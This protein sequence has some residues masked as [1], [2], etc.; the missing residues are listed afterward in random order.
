MNCRSVCF[1]LLLVVVLLPFRSPAPLIYRPGEGWTYESVG[2]ESGKWMRPRAKEQLE[3][4]QEAFDKKDY[5]LSLKAAHRVMHV[6][7]LSDF[8]PQAQYLV[9]RSYEAKGQDEKAFK[10]YQTVLEKQPK[11]AR[12]QD[13]LQRQ[14]IIADKFLAGKWFR[15]WGVIPYPSKDKTAEMYEKIVR[16]GPYSDI[17]PEAQ[18]KIGATREKQLEYPLAAKAY[19]TAA[20][21][22]HDR[23]KVAAEALFREGLAYH[24]QAQTAEYD[25]NTAAQAIATFTDFATL[26]PD[27]SRVPETQKRIA[28]LKTEQARGNFE[29]AKFYEH[30]KKFNAALIYYNEVLVLDPN[31][32]VAAPARERIAALKKRLDKPAK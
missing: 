13:I 30:Y 29:V 28:A 21:R 11:I 12:Y 17:A 23:P 24:K 22:Y 19:E 7:P 27:D 2:G 8:A 16:N 15:L 25:Q 26:Y 9:G 10:E 32:P 4:A 1:A 31:A 14:Y 3:V 18:M 5:D 20:D 6:W